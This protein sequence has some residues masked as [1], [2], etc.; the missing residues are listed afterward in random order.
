[1]ASGQTFVVTREDANQAIKDAAQSSGLID[2]SKSVINFNGNDQIVLKKGTEVV[3]SIGQVG[4]AEGK[5]IDVSLVRNPNIT[6]GDTIIDD[7]FDPSK[8]WTDLGKD[9]FTNLGSHTM[10][11]GPVDPNAVEAVNASN[12][13]TYVEA[14][15]EI[16]LSTG[17]AEAKIYYTLD[18]SEPTSSSTLY[19]EIFSY[20]TGCRYDH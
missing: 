11:V 20:Q 4:S 19:S 15:T 13:S 5:L 14:G 6:K 17:T 7:E 9:T 10:D 8:E 12:T 3:D 1:M 18:G 16:K 2:S